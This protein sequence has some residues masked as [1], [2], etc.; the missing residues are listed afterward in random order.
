MLKTVLD[1]LAFSVSAFLPQT[2]SEVQRNFSRR[3][4]GSLL[5]PRRAG[6][7]SLLS[8]VLTAG[9]T[10]PLGPVQSLL[11]IFFPG[12]LPLTSS[13]PPRRFA[14]KIHWNKSLVVLVIL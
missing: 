5:T 12:E 6:C 10:H 1:Q 9:S 14:M 7:S 11:A 3:L 2:V 8:S 13:C 4:P